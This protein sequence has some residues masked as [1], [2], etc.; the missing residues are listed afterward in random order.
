MA[1]AVLAPG[2]QSGNFWIHRRDRET[3]LEELRNM[4]I[5]PDMK[6]LGL[7]KGGRCHRWGMRHA[8]EG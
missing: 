4:Y 1:F 2:G 6:L 8:W 3:H 7:S 5:S